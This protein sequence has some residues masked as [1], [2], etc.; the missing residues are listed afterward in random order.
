MPN[1]SWFLPRSTIRFNI[2]CQSLQNQS[3]FSTNTGCLFPFHSD[4]KSW[5]YGIIISTI[6]VGPIRTRSMSSLEAYYGRLYFYFQLPFGILLCPHF[7]ELYHLPIRLRGPS[8][9][10]RSFSNKKWLLGTR[11]V[12]LIL[13]S[14]G[15]A[16]CNAVRF[17][18]QFVA[19][20]RTIRQ[21]WVVSGFPCEKSLVTSESSQTV[22]LPP[23][24]LRWD[25][26]RV[27]VQ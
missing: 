8:Y 18:M 3:T 10:L 6:H 7:F 20:P 4:Q 22:S 27:S 17:P 9:S 15:K 16:N 12:V 25:F 1:W 11:M 13:I 2:Y 19:F 23:N 14:S 26:S 24:R 21:N 5:I